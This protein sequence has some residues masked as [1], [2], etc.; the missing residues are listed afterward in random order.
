MNI[1]E[2]S[3]VYVRQS[4]NRRPKAIEE[5]PWPVFQPVGEV[6]L[7]ELLRKVRRRKWVILGTV[8]TVLFVVAIVL[9]KLTPR[10][11][12]VTHVV[13]NPQETKVADIE[14]VISGFSADA[15]TLETEMQIIRSRTL[16]SKTIEQL[17]LHRNPEFN[18]VLRPPNPLTT[19]LKDLRGYIGE[20]WL[21]VFSGIFD[22][23][24]LSQRE[25]F[26]DDQRRE[27][28]Q[29][30]IIDSFLENL[31]VEIAG[32]SRVIIITFDSES[33]R[34]A[35]LAVN[36]LADLY[37][38]AQLEAKFEATK[39]ANQWLN[40]RISELREEVSITEKFVESYR[41]KSG[42]IRGERDATLASEQISVLGVQHIMERTKLAEAQARLRQVE[43][44]LKL[45]DGIET[46]SE[47][48]A[49]E[50]IRNLR[51][52]EAELERQTAELSA[53]YGERHPKMINA[54]A[55]LRDLRGKIKVEVNKI[56]H[57]LRN[58]VAVARARAASLSAELNKLK[59]EVGQLNTQ[60]V[61][62]RALEREAVASRTLLENLLARS[63]ET[64]SQADFQQAD[65]T[66]LSYAAVPQFPSYPKKKLILAV[67]FVGAVFLGLLLVFVVEQLDLGF[68]SMEQIERLMGV[69]PLGLVPALTGLE[70]IGRKPES[71]ILDKPASAFGE[72]I[73]S[74][75]TNLLLSSADKPPK[76]ILVCASLP[77]EG[78][79]T[80]VISLARLLASIGQK[81]I[82]VDCDLRRP[83]VHKAF[84]I[85]SRPG[86]V[87]CLAG[88]AVLDD[89]IQED[90]YS[91]AYLL[92]VGGK[93]PHP[94]SLLG[95][96]SM[97]KLLD[98]I[99]RRYDAVILD[100]A[101]VAAVSDSLVLSRLVD[102]I[103]FL[104]RWRETRREVALDGLRQIV[105]AGGDVAGVL[106]TMVNVKEHAQYGFA[107]SGSYTGE[108]RKYYSG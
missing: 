49:S 62:L 2:G 81:V 29:E 22:D 31:E 6:D 75:H 12:A 25:E 8:I 33:P 61:Q 79:T 94:P 9:F 10:Y 68:R 24:G 39:R 96:E 38:V 7:Q 30:R 18:G 73:R 97:N 42:L 36:K 37:I 11:T 14:A 91:G 59:K 46:A 41:E 57:G 58:E 108:I 86:L 27:P 20:G 84:G 99:A 21:A 13:F 106:L 47:V 72:A 44:L 69:A 1:H 48:L 92:P 4:S 56:V 83:K 103:V 50:L 74:L 93:T 28:E 90:Q 5:S 23:E 76:V 66:I 3:N 85:A 40:D 100:S 80:V 95:S 67:A 63:K 54:R 70:A 64:I 71:Y 78:K 102:K 51:G 88:E 52:Q 107:D 26:P 77:K 34:T 65:A 89:V 101:P 105:D 32:R 17:E 15:E 60:E 16:A 19:I 55:Q 45:P 43:R 35:A 104:V 87:E 98:T 82:V 53:E